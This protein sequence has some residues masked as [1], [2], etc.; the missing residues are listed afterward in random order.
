MPGAMDPTLAGPSIPFPASSPSLSVFFLPKKSP[1][2]IPTAPGQRCSTWLCALPRAVWILGFIQ[3]IPS[4]AC[5][6]GMIWG[7]P[8]TQ[9][10]HCFW[11]WDK[12][13]CQGLLCPCRGAKLPGQPRRFRG[14]GQSSDLR[15]F[16]LHF[17]SRSP[18][19]T[20]GPPIYS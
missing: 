20:N 2:S 14:L 5:G 16:Y 12:P 6:M 19:K 15:C 1:C 7:L 9:Q 13:P 3:H 8:I 18:A 10:R 17:Q 11:D 4:P